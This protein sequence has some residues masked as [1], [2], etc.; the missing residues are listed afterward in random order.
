VAKADKTTAERNCLVCR[1]SMPQQQMLSL[2]EFDG[3][4]TFVRPNGR[5]AYVCIQDT[6]LD[7]L[8]IRC[9]SRAL[10]KQ[11]REFDKDRFL[12][13][14]GQYARS[15]ILSSLGLA[16]RC[17]QVE[18]GID[19]LKEASGVSVVL[20]ATDLSRRGQDKAQ[21]FGAHCF[22][23]ASELGAALGLNRVGVVRIEGRFAKQITQWLR[24]LQA[25]AVLSASEEPEA[26]AATESMDSMSTP[27]LCNAAMPIEV[28]HG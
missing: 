1:K 28:A 8:S 5:R 22:A 23:S 19:R 25:L 10:R 6:C 13:E 11:I 2:A 18:I 3:V 27:W 21:R 16:R 24:V 26:S 9:L 20:A 12:D 7:S 17:S 15:K 14:L 4:V